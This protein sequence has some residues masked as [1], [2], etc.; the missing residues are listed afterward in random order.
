MISAF[1]S[2]RVMIR[3]DGTRL[4]VVPCDGD[5]GKIALYLRSLPYIFSADNYLMEMR[6]DPGTCRLRFVGKPGEKFAPQVWNWVNSS[7]KPSRL[8]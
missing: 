8:L 2:G 7:R 1:V 4:I 5:Y 3:P 6:E